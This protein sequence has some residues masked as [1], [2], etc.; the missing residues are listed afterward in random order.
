MMF[1][2]EIKKIL[3]FKRKAYDMYNEV[4]CTVS[5]VYFNVSDR[6]IAIS[7]GYLM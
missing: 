2:V 7:I 6:Y 5:L 4:I 3:T 1:L